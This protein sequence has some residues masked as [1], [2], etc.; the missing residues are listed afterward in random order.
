[1]RSHNE[2]VFGFGESVLGAF[3][4]DDEFTYTHTE[5]MKAIKPYAKG[6]QMMHEI[7]ITPKTISDSRRVYLQF[8]KGIG[9]QLFGKTT[10]NS[11]YRIQHFHHK[12]IERLKILIPSHFTKDK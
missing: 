11:I 2:F 10:K 5:E 12:T 9:A 6:F 3:Y 7:P 1:M 4:E 8:S